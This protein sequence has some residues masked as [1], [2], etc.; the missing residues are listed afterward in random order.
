MHDMHCGD[1]DSKGDAIVRILALQ[2][3]CLSKLE[4]IE[5]KFHYSHF[6]LGSSD[7]GTEPG[8]TEAD[9]RSD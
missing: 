3:R 8:G 9:G 2:S 7:P 4:V 5:I 1:L 6:P